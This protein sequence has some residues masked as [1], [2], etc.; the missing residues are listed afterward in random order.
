MCRQGMGMTD[1]LLEVAERLYP[2][3]VQRYWRCPGDAEVLATLAGALADAQ[4]ERLAL[5]CLKR[6]L[7]LAPGETK[8]T[9]QLADLLCGCGD[10]AAAADV[11]SRTRFQGLARAHSQ[12]RLARL[13]FGPLA[14][15]QVAIELVE[16]LARQ[17]DAEADRELLAEFCVRLQLCSHSGQVPTGTIIE[18]MTAALGFRGDQQIARAV[19]T[20][21]VRVGR[22]EE[23]ADLA[24]RISERDSS[25]TIAAY[26]LGWA[27]TLSGQARKATGAFTRAV[28]SDPG[29][30]FAAWSLRCHLHSLGAYGPARAA[31]W[32]CSALWTQAHAGCK[33]R[34]WR[35]E[36][37]VGQTLLL[38]QDRRTGF[39]DALQNARY[40]SI[41]RRAGATVIVVA[42]QPLVS[43][44]SKADGVSRAISSFDEAVQCDFESAGAM[45]WMLLNME[46]SDIAGCVPYLR[47]EHRDVQRWRTRLRTDG[48][49]AV[50]VAWEGSDAH[51]ESVL[52]ERPICTRRFMSDTDLRGLCGLQNIRLYSLQTRG[53]SGARRDDLPLEIEDITQ[54]WRDFYDTAA[55]IAALDAVVT[56]DT[57]I[58]HLAGALSRPTFVL[59]PFAASWRWE[60]ERDDSP[61]YPT[62]RLLR[63]SQSGDWS[64]V[65]GAAAMHLRNLCRAHDEI[66]RLTDGRPTIRIEASTDAHRHP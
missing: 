63:Q 31:W 42:R 13:L 10:Y 2:A 61:W 6:A 62:I 20:A 35:G 4:Y 66:P 21:L 59:L 45:P 25:D 37:V 47:V 60:I 17:S 55:A 58:A 34:V 41:L 5:V 48:R 52:R 57:S 36:P 16:S 56:I 7:A 33:G 12:R 28:A 30:G 46:A 29:C 1:E 27:L 38:R 9:Q 23:A 51:A 44:L 22:Y 3:L 32:N 8:W 26:T 64:S 50:G 40:A 24:A 11:L 19:A 49:L 65:I 18:R 39:G 15:P 53:P 43:L 14:R 54:E